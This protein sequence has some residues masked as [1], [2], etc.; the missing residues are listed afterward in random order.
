LCAA[1]STHVRA[2]A[3]QGQGSHPRNEVAKERGRRTNKLW[4]SHLGLDDL[5]R[6]LPIPDVL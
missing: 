5:S 2:G 6:S 4:P 3:R 1:C